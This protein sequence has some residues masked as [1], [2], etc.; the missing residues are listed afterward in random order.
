MSM[1]AVIKNIIIHLFDVNNLIIYAF[2]GKTEQRIITG[3]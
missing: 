2:I 3:L 1:D